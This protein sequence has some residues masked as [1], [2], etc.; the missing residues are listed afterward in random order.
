MHPKNEQDRRKVLSEGLKN[1]NPRREVTSVV[2]Y[3]YFLA[4]H[5]LFLC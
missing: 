4:L 2:I 3:I 5:E 1:L